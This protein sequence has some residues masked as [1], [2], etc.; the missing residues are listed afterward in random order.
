MGH[1]GFLLPKNFPT[2]NNPAASNGA[3]NLMRCKQ[4]GIDPRGIR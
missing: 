1:P 2:V 4:R 3:W